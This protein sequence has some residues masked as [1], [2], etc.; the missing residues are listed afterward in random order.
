LYY[1]SDSLKLLLLTEFGELPEVVLFWEGYY[2]LN[3]RATELDSLDCRKYVLC[4]DL[5]GGEEHS[6]EDKRQAFEMFDTIL[7]TYGYVFARFYPELCQT[8]RVV[9]VPH[10]ASPD[11]MLSYNERPENVI[12]L[13]GAVNH[14]YPLPLR[15]KAL[16][17][18]VKMSKMG[19][20]C[21]PQTSERSE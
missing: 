21:T 13:S 17:A 14:Y 2:L 18:S 1:S 19:L 4:D 16:H 5:H 11:F 12:F 7:S 8:R 3:Q 20:S 15:V 9:R 6:E 10:S